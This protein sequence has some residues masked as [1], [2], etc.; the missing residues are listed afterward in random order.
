MRVCLLSAS[1][2]G[3]N[4]FMPAAWV[5]PVS[6]NPPLFGVAVGKQRFTYNLIKE[7]GHFA[8]NIPGVDFKEKLEKFGRASGIEGDKFKL[9]GVTPEKCGK[10]P[11]FAIAEALAT[12]EF[13]LVKEIEFGDHV[14]FVGEL[15][16]I[17]KRREGKGIYQAAESKYIEI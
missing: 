5:Y 8:I 1:H 17:K 3:K 11:C 14:L 12:L 6:A 2:G 15:V 7:N 4:N 9:W 16:N 13:K 10:I